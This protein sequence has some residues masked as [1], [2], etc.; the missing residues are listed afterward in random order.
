MTIFVNLLLQYYFE[1]VSFLSSSSVFQ[2]CCCCYYYYYYRY[3]LYF[4]FA[5]ARIDIILIL[6]SDDAMNARLLRQAR[7]R[8]MIQIIKFTL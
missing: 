2:Y 5:R 1:A 7:G 3:S 6:K 4:C 8:G